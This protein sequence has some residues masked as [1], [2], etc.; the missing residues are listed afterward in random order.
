MA[1]AAGAAPEA[2]AP[3]FPAG[4]RVLVVDDD[5]LCLLIVE[6]MLKR[7]NYNVTTCSSASAALGL[8]REQKAD[9]DIVLSDVYMP[10]MD[11]FKLLE[12]IGLELDLPVIMMSANGETTVVLRGITHGAVDYLLKPVRI[13]ELRNIWQHVVRKKRGA[14]SGDGDEGESKEGDR[15]KVRK[16][17]DGEDEDIKEENTATAK[18]PRVVWSVELHQQFVNAVNQLGID[19]AVPKR[20]LDLMGV[21]GLTRENVA[22]HLQKY[23]L[24]LKRLQGVQ[25]QQPPQP[26]GYPMGGMDGL[27]Q[28]ASTP[29]V[30]ASQPAATGVPMQ[31]HVTNGHSLGQQSPGQQSMYVQGAAGLG[32]GM[33]QHPQQQPQHQ[34]QQV[35]MMQ[36]Q[37]GQ[38]Q[39]QLQQ[40]QMQHPLGTV[41]VGGLP[42]SQ[43]GYGQG[44]QQQP[45][46]VNPQL[47]N[48]GAPSGIGDSMLG[49]PLLGQQGAALSGLQGRPQQQQFPG[50]NAFQGLADSGLPGT[51][52]GTDDILGMFLKDGGLI[53]GDTGV[54]NGSGMHTR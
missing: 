26:Q 29:T 27:Q 23:R 6:K 44:L 15:G 22:S 9:F 18:K 42:G 8:L 31:M 40:P 34:Q 21:Q 32:P 54:Q 2:A 20:I 37:H 11:G 3:A 36:M 16:R 46:A 14:G 4:L 39:P 5:P 19:K 45:G 28:H 33:M 10:D 12:L 13:E 24:Y 43:M 50:G 53:D 51:G 25:P 38:M 48:V 49:G 17:K 30:A 41:P 1:S 52:D 47:F 35:H 7:C